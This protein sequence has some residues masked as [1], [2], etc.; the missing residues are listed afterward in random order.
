MGQFYKLVEEQKVSTV[1][2]QLSWS[3]YCELLSIKDINGVNYYISTTER[4]N[5]SVRELRERIKNR[6]YQR[7][8]DN[9]KL[10][11]INKE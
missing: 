8:D 6:E 11:L 5:L 3:H 7:L 10:K 4:Y 2:T 1:S 9:T